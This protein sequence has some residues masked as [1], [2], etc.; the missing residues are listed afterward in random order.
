MGGMCIGSHAQMI[1]CGVMLELPP[2]VFNAIFKTE[3]CFAVYQYIMSFV[4]Q[5]CV[6]ELYQHGGQCSTPIKHC[7]C[8]PDVTNCFIID[9]Y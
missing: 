4:C 7:L 5:D 6:K 1:S 3:L 2:S 8:M 9:G